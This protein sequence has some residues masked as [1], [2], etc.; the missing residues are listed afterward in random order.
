M[1]SSTPTAD[2]RAAQAALARPDQFDRYLLIDDADEFSPE[3]HILLC[4]RNPRGLEVL[5]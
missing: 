2:T 1:R 4:E 3:I 5:S